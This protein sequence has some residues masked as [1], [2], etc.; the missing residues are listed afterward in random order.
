MG[1]GKAVLVG[2]AKLVLEGVGLTMEEEGAGLVV[3]ELVLDVEGMGLIILEVNIT[4][5]VL[6]LSVIVVVGTMV[7][8]IEDMVALGS[9]LS[10]MTTL[11]DEVWLKE[12]GMLDTALVVTVTRVWLVDVAK[13]SK[14]FVEM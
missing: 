9:T 6:N 13:T 7:S 10:E 11:T 8:V 14:L 3:E 1:V 2:L 4:K 12:T 5:L